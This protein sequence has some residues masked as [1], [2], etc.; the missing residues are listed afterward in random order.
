M[1]GDSREHVPKVRLGIDTVQLRRAN[2][3]VDRRGALAARRPTPRRGNFPVRE[4]R[5]VTTRKR[6]HLQDRLEKPLRYAS[7]SRTLLTSVSERIGF[8]NAAVAPTNVA[9]FNS[10][11]FK[12]PDITKIR[13]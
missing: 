10:A 13:R 9:A 12:Y 11:P 5:S 7:I 1:F 4:R 3:A 2:Q 8:G 6:A